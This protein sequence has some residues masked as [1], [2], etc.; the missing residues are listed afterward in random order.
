[1]SSTTTNMSLVVP[2][3]GETNYPTSISSS[4]T[5]ID[6][7]DHTSG[8]GVQI[9]SG[10]IEDAAISAA[11]IA[12][13]AVTTAKILD[14]NVTT[15]KIAANAVTR[16]KLESVGQQFSSDV[17]YN[18]TTHDSIGNYTD[19]TSATLSITTTG[20]PVIIAWVPRAASFDSYFSIGYNSTYQ[21]S[22]ELK[23]LRDTNTVM[24]TTIG[25]NIQGSGITPSGSP[26]CYCAGSSVFVLDTPAG[27]T[28][29][30]K[31]QASFLTGLDF[32]AIGRL[33]AFE[34]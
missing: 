20:R 8:K 14:S 34:L 30:Y 23:L 4:M 17:S 7:H 15:A 5:L 24:L 21:A 1:M 11:K 27:G 22:V 32:T 12:S 16:A 2:T 3:T 6:A 9:P 13:N 19:I 10:G 26:A 33:L 29:T 31:L 28:Y 18:T 25:T